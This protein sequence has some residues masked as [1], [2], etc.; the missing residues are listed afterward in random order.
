MKKQIS[1]LCILVSILSNNIMAADAD[2]SRVNLYRHILQ[3]DKIAKKMFQESARKK[4][5]LVGIDYCLKYFKCHSRY[6][7]NSLIREMILEKGGGKGGIEEI[8]NFIEKQFKGGKYAF[9]DLE[10]CLELYDSPEYQTEI[11][12]IVKKYCKECK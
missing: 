5:E 1:I 4:Y 3:D 6:Y 2:T 11:E 7:A 10:S 9:Q 12:R 8:K